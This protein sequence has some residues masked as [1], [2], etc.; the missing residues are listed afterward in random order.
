MSADLKTL[1]LASGMDDAEKQMW[2]ALVPLLDEQAKAEL[3]RTLK[4]EI[5]TLNI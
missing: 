4:T 1:L 5:E 2:L 3:S